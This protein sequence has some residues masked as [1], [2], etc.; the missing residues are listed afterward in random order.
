M[1]GTK[2]DLAAL[3]GLA[4]GQ[5]DVGYS[6]PRSTPTAGPDPRPYFCL[7]SLHCL[8]GTC[9]LLAWSHDTFYLWVGKS[10]V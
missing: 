6:S 3:P 2:R 9:D 5:S 10:R 8:E 1:S 4:P 7:E